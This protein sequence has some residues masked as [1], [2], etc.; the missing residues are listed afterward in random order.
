MLA[1]VAKYDLELEQLDVKTGGEDIYEGT[2][3]LCTKQKWRASLSSE[4][5]SL[6]TQTKSKT[7]V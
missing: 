2:R 7:V 4:E 6:R 1:M 5:V 3:R